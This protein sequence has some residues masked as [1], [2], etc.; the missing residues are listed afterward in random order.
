MFKLEPCWIKKTRSDVHTQIEITWKNASHMSRKW[1]WI[2]ENYLFTVF[3]ISYLLIISIIFIFNLF[4]LAL[5]NYCIQHLC[6][7]VSKELCLKSLF[8]GI[9]INEQRLI[10]NASFFLSRNIVPITSSDE[11]KSLPQDD[12]SVLITHLNGKVSIF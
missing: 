9:G 11:F 4:F 10:A 2:C 12:V 6:L 7:H 3:S 5:R 8:Y 1:I